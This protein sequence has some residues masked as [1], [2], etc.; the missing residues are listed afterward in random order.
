MEFT[1]YM[2]GLYIKINSLYL[3]IWYK[4]RNYI[5][6]GNDELLRKPDL[7]ITVT[8]TDIDDFKSDPEN[9]VL[10]DDEEIVDNEHIELII[11][12]KKITEALLEREILLVH[13]SVV[14]TDNEA[15]MITG[16]SGIGKT[17]RSKQW[18]TNIP[19][20]YFLNGDK[21]YLI[22]RD[23]QIFAC[24]SPWCGKERFSSNKII[25][26]H[27]I[28]FLERASKT[29]LVELSFWEAFPLLI[30][31]TYHSY[32][33][34]KIMETIRILNK[35]DGKVKLFRFLSTKEPESVIEAY[36]IARSGKNK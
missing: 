30:N 14:V 25:P 16:P 28:F 5:C 23:E 24:G 8:I 9:R 3:Q 13:G 10:W 35:M 19:G 34:K 7:T 11:V 31:Q 22:F 27:A 18:I 33:S 29:Q 26:L 4:C 12:H 32:D 36:N 1:I 2:A 21:P 17:Y 6:R 15:Y 20:S